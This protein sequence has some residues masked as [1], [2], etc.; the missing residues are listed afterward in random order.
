MRYDGHLKLAG[1]PVS[2]RF[3]MKDWWC[4][5]RGSTASGNH[6]GVDLVCPE[7][8]GILA[9]VNAWVMGFGFEASPAGHWLLL[10]AEST[11]WKWHIYFAHMQRPALVASLARTNGRVQ[12]GEPIGVVGHTG[13]TDLSHLHFQVWEQ[14]K[15]QP[16]RGDL[17]NMYY[18]LLG[19]STPVGGDYVTRTPV[20]P[21]APA[22]LHEAAW[23]AMLA[24]RH[25][26]IMEGKDYKIVDPVT[27]RCQCDHP[28]TK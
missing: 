3:R 9:P 6:N 26:H 12:A 20:L 22:G 11:N 13:G 21:D 18:P 24:I 27:G 17:I 8:S 28:S 23:A 16:G 10:G 1:C 7:G 15:G 2:H 19:V 25:Q 5:G 4:A 14:R